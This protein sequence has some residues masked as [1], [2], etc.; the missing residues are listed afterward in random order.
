[1]AV[2]PSND[3]DFRRY[4]EENKYVI[5]KF[6]AEW[7]GTCRLLLPKYT[8]L[9][10]EKRFEDVAFL[11]MDIEESPKTKI[12]VGVESLPCFAVFNKGKKVNLATIGTDADEDLDELVDMLEDLVD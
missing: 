7:S 11:D 12:D 1:M 8:E 2:L 4:L 5:V 10:E 9:S 6:Y 3:D